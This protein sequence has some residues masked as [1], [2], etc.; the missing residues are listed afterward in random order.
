M[1]CWKIFEIKVEMSGEKIA[2]PEGTWV[3]VGGIEMPTTVYVYGARI[4]K[5]RGRKVIKN[6]DAAQG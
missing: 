1:K 2:A 3:L 5:L 4:H 6:A